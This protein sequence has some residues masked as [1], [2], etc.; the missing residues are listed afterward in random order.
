[1]KKYLT[2]KSLIVAL[3][4]GLFAH[5]FYLQIKIEEAIKASNSAEYEARRAYDESE[6]AASIAEEALDYAKKASEYAE[7]AYE[8]AE[9][10]ASNSFGNQ[11]FSCP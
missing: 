6:N 10:A 8:S 5:N 2:Y 1:M 11:C 4:I 3:I 9:K 7:Y